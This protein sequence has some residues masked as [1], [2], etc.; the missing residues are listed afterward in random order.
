MEAR[1]R[2]KRNYSDSIPQCGGRAWPW[3]IS[4]LNC[5]NTGLWET[6]TLYRVNFPGERFALCKAHRV[7]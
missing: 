3:A 5:C 1:E 6:T 7:V 2:R 4:Q